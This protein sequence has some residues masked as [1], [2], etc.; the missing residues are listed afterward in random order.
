MYYRL[1]YIAASDKER[2]GDTVCNGSKPLNIGQGVSCNVQLPDSDMYEP[3]VY[4][5]ILKKE[6]GDC[7]YLVRRTDCHKVTI[8]GV[9]VYAA[10]ILQSGDKLS[11][12]DD[13]IYTELQFEI[14]DYGEYDASSVIVYKKHKSSRLIVI[15][16]LLTLLLCVV[17]MACWMIATSPQKSIRQMDMTVYNQ[18]V[19]RL[20]VDALYLVC[21]YETDGRWCRDTIEAVSL[22]KYAVGSAFLTENGLLVTARHCLEPWLNDV[23][24]DGSDDFGK[25]SPEV[26]LAVKAAT[27]NELEEGRR[28]A[29]LSHCIVSNGQDRYELNSEN[30]CMDKSRDLVIRLGS[31]EH[32]LYWR[33]IIPVAS[34]REMEL[35]DYAYM[36]SDSLQGHSKIALATAKDFGKLGIQGNGREIEVMGHPV[37]DNGTEEVKIV[38]GSLMS[39]KND[40]DGRHLTEGCMQMN[41][42]INPGNSGGPVFALID[43]KVKV[44]GIVSKVDS[45]A[46]QG[47]FWAVPVTEVQRS[48]GKPERD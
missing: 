25:M 39:V 36:K 21:D 1:T 34:R 9:A 29:V 24:W 14:F 32:P 8:N 40:D 44:I 6:D 26:R 33:S 35:G 7:W 37:D 3:Q 4:A 10:Q 13:T 31:N 15:A 17:G 28:Y 11:F 42:Q 30:F 18:D 46:D 43:G 27:S 38:R 16:V 22:E 2:R 12:S 19:Y 20:T 5:T 41:A 47:V 48:L 45:H 23:E